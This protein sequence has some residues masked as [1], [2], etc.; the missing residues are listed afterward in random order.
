MQ[1]THSIKVETQS[2]AFGTDKNINVFFSYKF[3]T[4][5]LVDCFHSYCSNG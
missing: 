2:E 1:D 4:E 3:V 5:S